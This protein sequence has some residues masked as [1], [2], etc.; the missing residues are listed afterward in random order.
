MPY[1][2][3]ALDSLKAGIIFRYSNSIKEETIIITEEMMSLGIFQSKT[4]DIRADKEVLTIKCEGEIIDDKTPPMIADDFKSWM[5]KF[6]GQS[7]EVNIFSSK[8]K[9]KNFTAYFFIK[10]G[11]EINI[12]PYIFP[13]IFQLEKA[14]ALDFLKMLPNLRDFSNI[15]FD[16]KDGAF[17]LLGFDLFHRGAISYYVNLK[18]TF[19][20]IYPKDPK[21]K[22]AIKNVNFSSHI[23]D[24]NG[25]IIFKLNL[26][27]L[28]QDKIFNDYL[29][30]NRALETKIKERTV[31]LE[32]FISSIGDEFLTRGDYIYDLSKCEVGSIKANYYGPI[33]S[34]KKGGDKQKILTVEAKID[35]SKTRTETAAS[36]L[37]PGNGSS[38]IDS[39]VVRN[40]KE[41]VGITQARLLNIFAAEFTYGLPKISLQDVGGSSI[42]HYT[43]SENQNLAQDFR[44]KMMSFLINAFKLKG[45]S[46]IKAIFSRTNMVGILRLSV[47]LDENISQ[48][49]AAIDDATWE[50]L[51]SVF[52]TNYKYE[53][54]V[55]NKLF[56]SLSEEINSA[57]LNPLYKFPEKPTA[58]MLLTKGED[59]TIL[60]IGIDE[61]QNLAI[62]NK[63]ASDATSS[64]VVDRVAEI[65][66]K[67][68]EQKEK[69]MLGVT[70]CS[71]AFDFQL[72]KLQ[73]AP[74]STK[75]SAESDKENELVNEGSSS[76]TVD[77]EAKKSKRIE[78]ATQAK[79]ELELENPTVRY[80]IDEVTQIPRPM[81]KNELVAYVTAEEARTNVIYNR[82][83]L[84]K[85]QIIKCS[86]EEI[87]KIINERE[88]E[89]PTH[90]YDRSA[91]KDSMLKLM[92]REQLLVHIE[93][94]ERL[95]GKKFSRTKARD[96]G[97]FVEKTKS[98]TIM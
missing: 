66:Q 28:L 71:S 68:Q 4:D 9:P 5:K 23:D 93:E 84:K 33:S 20:E 18:Y 50:S 37:P 65:E 91:A 16:F 10:D 6:N 59:A 76:F 49:I 70:A 81:N 98:C 51:V 54:D 34:A 2:K 3:D 96:E 32:K 47:E 72:G 53:L 75:T 30:A 56:L 13:Y 60:T 69:Q 64:V 48:R 89:D 27:G 82:D 17:M 19:D 55:F 67:M 39:I 24:Q 21:T 26:S 94:Q 45:E 95:T 92:T 79:S 77:D 61:K 12:P 1:S 78:L 63:S 88:T 43:W 36:S 29:Q 15:S 74:D 73:D 7:I 38:V 52:V 14:F 62:E 90:L 8:K 44:D 87:L 57:W 35:D 31:R 22:K 80:I 25:Q 85:G 58:V 42:I 41:N 11:S 46:E 97:L 86:E 83:A 40:L